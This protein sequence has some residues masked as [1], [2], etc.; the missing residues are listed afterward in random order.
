MI[1]QTVG[2]VKRGEFLHG[3]IARDLGDDRRGGDGGAAGVAVDDGEFWAGEPGL[4]VA[5]DEAEMRL[6]G[7]ARDRAAHGEQ[8]CAENIVRLDFFQ[9]SDADGPSDLGVRA[10]EM[11]QLG[12]MLSE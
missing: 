3:A 8:A 10:K 9:R 4:L 7:E 1:L 2:R 6:Q 5:V 11:A 12:A